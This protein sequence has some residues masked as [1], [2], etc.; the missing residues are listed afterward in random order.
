MTRGTKSSENA[1][2]DCDWKCDDDEK[3]Q[4]RRT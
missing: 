2:F 4:T 3:N 1:E